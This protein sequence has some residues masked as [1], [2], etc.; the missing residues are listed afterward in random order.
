MGAKLMDG[1]LSLVQY[2][3]KNLTSFRAMVLEESIR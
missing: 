1:W 2:E 3:W